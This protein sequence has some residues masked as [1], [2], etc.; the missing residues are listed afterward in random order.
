MIQRGFG[1]PTSS[2]YDDDLSEVTRGAILGVVGRRGVAIGMVPHPMRDE[3]VPGVIRDREKWSP[4]ARQ[5]YDQVERHLPSFR[6]MAATSHRTMVRELTSAE[7][8]PRDWWQHLKLTLRTRW[9][10]LFG[11]LDVKWRQPRRLVPRVVGP[12]SEVA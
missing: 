2:E 5:A 10:R 1:D 12:A 9:P 6:A 8:L 3:M 11:R 4:E 7:L